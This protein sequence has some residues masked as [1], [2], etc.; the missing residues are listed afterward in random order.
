MDLR[1]A[2]EARDIG[3]L[4]QMQQEQLGK[5]KIDTRIDNE[6][7]LRS[8]PEVEILLEEFLREVFMKRP[9]DIREFAAVH[10][11]DPDLPER[12]KREMEERKA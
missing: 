10:F 3:A 5:F 2:M 8:H 12:I 9:E 1:R 7:Y 6:K 11:T 4:S